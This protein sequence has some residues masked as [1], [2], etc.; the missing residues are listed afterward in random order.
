MQ[1]VIDLISRVRNIRSEMNIKPGERVRLLIGSP[2]E[3]LRKVYSAS[4]DQISKLAR[5]SDVSISDQLDAPR[6]SARHVL[7]GGAEV[8]IP[9]E[10]LI[11]F[12][13]ERQRLRKELDK[14]QA[15]A[16]KVE[17]QLGNA[18]FIERAPEEKVSELRARIADIAQRSAQ[19]TQTI[20]NLQ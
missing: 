17:A 7:V 20:E 15:E 6:A 5:A 19:L 1:A 16:S 10:G 12:E 11:D 13:Q 9:L 14:L 4:V 8:A 3:K 2:D 18:N